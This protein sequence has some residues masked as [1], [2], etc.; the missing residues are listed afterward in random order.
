MIDSMP[1]F[2]VH[3]H[4]AKHLHWDFR[5]ELDGVLKSWAVPKQPPL[6]AGVKRL[7]IQ[8]EDHETG[9]ADFEGTI[10]EGQYGAGKVEIWDKGDYELIE[11]TDNRIKF[12][13]Q[14]KHLKGEYSLVRFERS[15]KKHWLLFKSK[16]SRTIHEKSAGIVVFRK[17]RERKYLLLHYESGHW[18][19]PKGH[20]EKG[21]SEKEAAKRELKE[22]TGVKDIK[23]IEG[24]KENIRYFYRRDGQ[25]MH[26]EVVFFLGET[27]STKIR[28]S[29]STKAST[30]CRMTRPW[31]ASLTRTQGMCWRKRLSFSG[32]RRV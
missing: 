4:A 23:F 6:R 21:E 29:S 15:G 27:K 17:N 30:G 32:E 13:L 25:L 1:L 3:K 28:L 26:K 7:A 16:K 9:Y 31:S 14:G 10:P 20:I 19:F 18:D 24:F 22:E 11:K 8:V 5:L 2:V 12:V